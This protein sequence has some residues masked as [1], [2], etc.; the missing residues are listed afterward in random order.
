MSGNGKMTT[1]DT[2]A[3]ATLEDTIQKGLGTFVEVGNALAEIRERKLYRGTH[4]TFED[5]CRERWDMSADFARKRIRASQTV[6]AL[7]SNTIVSVLPATESQV[8]PL[9]TIPMEKVGEVWQQVIDEA[10]KGKDGRPRITAKQVEEAAAPWKGQPSDPKAKEFDHA[11]QMQRVYEWV[12][13]RAEEWPEGE[14]EPLSK[15]LIQLSQ[16]VL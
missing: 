4:K 15:I 11:K 5:Y 14:R 12:S 2:R 3:L 7:K 1:K 6:A 9:T 16:E 13:D 10:P 8:R